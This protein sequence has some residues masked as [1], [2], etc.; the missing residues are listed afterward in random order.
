MSS[1]IVQLRQL[2]TILGEEAGDSIDW[3]ATEAAYNVVFPEDYKEFI[4]TFG[5]GTIEGM[6]GVKIPIVTSD[7]TVRRVDTLPRP[8]LENPD[9]SKWIRPDLGEKYRLTQILVWGDTDSADT[10]GWIVGGPDPEKWPLA[11]YSRGDAAWSVYHCGMVEFLVKLLRGEFTECPISD[12][13]LVGLEN[14]RFLHDRDEE[15]LAEQGIYPW[16]E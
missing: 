9:V 6:I 11:V 16:D 4:R 2:L 13:S 14:P 8:A 10:L 3:K 12:T 15:R 1:H 7:P 5:N